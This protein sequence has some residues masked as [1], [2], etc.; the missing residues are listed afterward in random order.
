MRMNHEPLLVSHR[1]GRKEYEDNSASGCVGSLAHGLRGFETDLHLTKDGVIFVMH[2]SN[3]D[4]TT[5]GFGLVEDMTRD[6]IS[7]FR[8]KMTG[9]RI[10][11]LEDLLEIFKDRDDI[12]VEFEMKSNGRNLKSEERLREYCQKIHDRVSAAMPAGTYTFT[13]FCHDTLEMMRSVDADTRLGLI[14]DSLTED[15]I[16]FA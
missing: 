9:D 16:A 10:P 7:Q 12:H 14:R 11:Y 2:N 4:F 5:T 15:D 13:S 1:G 6:E 3:L 8:L